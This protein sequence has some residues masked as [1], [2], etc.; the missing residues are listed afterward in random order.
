MFFVFFEVLVEVGV[1]NCFVNFG[2]D[3]FSILEVM[4]KGQREMLDIFFWIIMCF[5]EMVV[6]FMV[7]GYVRLSGEV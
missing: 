6:L 4:V 3:Y 5:N 7:D 2:L 1:K